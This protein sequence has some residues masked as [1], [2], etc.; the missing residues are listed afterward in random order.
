MATPGTGWPMT[1][2]NPSTARKIRGVEIRK[3]TRDSEC[4]YAYRI[5]F[6]N[7]RGEL[8]SRT[9]DSAEDALDFRSRL[10]LLTRAGDL[11]ELEAGIEPLE[12]FFTDYWR[13]YVEARLAS[14]TRTKYRSLWNAHIRPRL[15][16]MQ[17][18]QITPLVVSNFVREL[19]E[20]GV[21]P[22]NLRSCLGML[23]SMFARAVEWDRT[24]INVV[25]LVAKPRVQRRRTIRL[26]RPADVEALRQHMLGNPRHGP[27]DATLVSVLAYTG[28]RP[29]EAL[30]L[31]YEHLRENTIVI[32]QKCVDGQILKG[33]KTQR[34]PRCLPLLEIV[35]CDLRDYQLACGRSGG[36]IFTRPEGTPWRTYDWSYW[37]EH[38]WQPA[39]AATG[40]AKITT[41]TDVADGKRKSR[42]AY[43][44]PVPY[45]L[46][47]SFASMLIHEGQH[48]LV[49]ISEWMGHSTATLLA[50]YAHVMADVAGQSL[51]PSERA[52]KAARATHDQPLASTTAPRGRPV[53]TQWRYG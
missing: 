40:L 53:V 10:R 46:R 41:T 50:H 44:G 30:A 29:E 47:H 14:S 37:R 15:G 23:Q 48:S 21:G 35:R 11:A 16:A 7:A 32:E 1:H 18:R 26:L 19:Q 6:R 8:K 17:L 25:K 42:R 24:R 49:Q 12:Q 4:R 13:L 45:D 34:A 51:L 31:E 43:E 36:L 22:Q 5:R 33:Q 2:E 39:C 52:I 9:F 28:L 27:R 20:D 3:R 38:V